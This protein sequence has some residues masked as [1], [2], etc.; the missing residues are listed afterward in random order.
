[1]KENFI[2][3]EI[4]MTEKEKIDNLGLTI[5]ELDL[6]VR[7][8]NALLRNGYETLED[9]VK[10]NESDIRHLRNLGNRSFN[11]IMKKVRFYGYSTLGVDTDAYRKLVNNGLNEKSFADVSII[12]ANL[13]VKNVPS[14]DGYDYF[15]I[16]EIIRDWREEHNFG[17]YEIR[18]GWTLTYHPEIEV[19]Y[20]KFRLGYAEPVK[21]D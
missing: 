18:P 5:Y 20:I 6:S 19:L 12:E 2:Q 3:E 10:A 17:K 16:I 9:I 11:E 13:Q 15:K 14:L 7:S 4:K 8:T 21:E 1:M